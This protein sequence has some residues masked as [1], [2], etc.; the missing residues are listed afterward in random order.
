MLNL[1]P[2]HW[3]G[4]LV[5]GLLASQCCFEQGWGRWSSPQRL[6]KSVGEEGGQSQWPP[7]A[8]AHPGSLRPA[9]PPSLCRG[10]GGW[11]PPICVWNAGPVDRERM[12]VTSL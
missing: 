6:E 1:A 8:A 4:K 2:D 11:L 12:R 7:G 5:L 3:M 10:Q 9:A